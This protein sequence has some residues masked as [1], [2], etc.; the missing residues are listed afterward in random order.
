MPQLD[1]NYLVHRVSL[2]FEF[3]MEHLL[4][5]AETDEF[6]D[7]LLKILKHVKEEGVRQPLCLGIHRSDYL[8]HAAPG[9]GLVPKQ[10][11]INTIAS[12]F[13][14][15]SGLVSRLHRYLLQRAPVSGMDPANCPDNTPVDAIADGIADASRRYADAEPSPT[16]TAAARRLAAL[17]VVQVRLA[18]RSGRL[19][20]G[21]NPPAAT[22]THW[23]AG[24][25]NI[26]DQRLLELRIWERHGLPVIRATLG[27]VRPLPRP[28]SRAVA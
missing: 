14:G 18:R 15:L 21:L 5:V 13:A 11:E 20:P 27:E 6:Q 7:R 17:F 25:G 24:E 1:F 19:I 16:P 23:Q 28:P 2:D 9:D 22:E 12:S 3:L 4:P 10:V 8:L 26:F